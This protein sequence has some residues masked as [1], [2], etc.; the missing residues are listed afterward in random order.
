MN[1]ILWCCL[2]LLTACSSEIKSPQSNQPEITQLIKNAIIID[3]SGAAGYAG[4]VRFNRNGIIA[5]GD[6]ETLTTDEVVFANGMV[7]APGF[8][9]THSHHDTGLDEA[10]QAIAAV[11]QGI[12]T[13]VVG[14][15]G[16]SK[17]PLADFKQ[18]LET[19]PPAIN[20]A[21]YTGH[22]T[23]RFEVMGS[24][25]KREANLSEINKMQDILAKDLEDGSLGLASGLEYDPGIYSNTS[26]VIELAKTTAAANGRYI[27]HMR[28]EDRAFYEAVEE[29][30]MIGK[31]AELPV[32]I[33]HMKLAALNIWGQAGD[34]LDRLEEARAAGIDVTADVYPY[35]YWQSTLTVL[36]PDRDFHDLD[37]ARYALENLAPADGLTLAFYA[38]DPS[39]V[40]MNV[41]EIATARG[42]SNEETYLQLIRDAYEGFSDEELAN[43]EEPRESVMGV[44]MSEDDIAT[45]VAWPHSNICSDGSSEGHPRGYGAF[46]RAIRQFVREQETVTLEEM[47]QKMTSLSAA[48]VGIEGRGLI[49]PGY[50]ADLVLFDPDTITDNATIQQHDRLSDGIIHVW[51]N[52]QTVWLDQHPTDARP[53]I[54][55]ARAQNN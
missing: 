22:G 52:G 48:H 41:A 18:Q 46:P 55:V 10:P 2:A 19:N 26:E 21:S 12:T 15:D 25:Y 45:L 54:F 17:F 1:K 13:I 44:S 27:S 31:E 30:I 43:L 34:V 40:G 11:S 4:D 29:L 23:I 50:S 6:L 53:G 49:L 47:I 36:L 14:N 38:P 9:D 3:G 51:V 42:K 33:S 5:I 7:V 8:I 16:M 20:V 28:S 35:T 32:Q 39:L 24:D 37:A